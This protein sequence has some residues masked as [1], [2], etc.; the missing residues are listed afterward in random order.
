MNLFL[1]P[2]RFGVVDSIQHLEDI[3]AFDIL[4]RVSMAADAVVDRLLGQ[5][6]IEQEVIYG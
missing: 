1:Y 2:I 5:N 6:A 4:K 3:L